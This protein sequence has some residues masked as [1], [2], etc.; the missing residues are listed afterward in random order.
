MMQARSVLP[1]EQMK[2]PEALDTI[3]NLCKSGKGS[4]F[5]LSLSTCF[6]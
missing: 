1:L 6:H 4:L 3:Y 5:S 2:K